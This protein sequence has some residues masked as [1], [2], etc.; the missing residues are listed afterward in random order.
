MHHK[1]ALYAYD[2]LFVLQLLPQNLP[3]HS[4]LSFVCG[5][6]KWQQVCNSGLT[7]L[8]FP[9]SP[10]L[11]FIA[12]LI[13]KLYFNVTPAVGGWAIPPEL[14]LWYIRYRRIYS[15]RVTPWTSCR[16]SRL[17]I[18]G[19]EGWGNLSSVLVYVSMS[20]PTARWSPRSCQ[21]NRI[22]RGF[23]EFGGGLTSVP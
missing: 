16:N 19:E 17:D 15:C 11:Q 10:L 3:Y 1:K 23:K 4:Y 5:V 13:G 12:I 20:W 2:K 22:Q 9:D 14:C 6:P 21:W 8:Y 7:V 18:R